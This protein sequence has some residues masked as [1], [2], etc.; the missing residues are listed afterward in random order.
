MQTITVKENQTLYDFALE[1]YGTCEA[2]GELLQLNADIINDP[3]ALRARGIDSIA[4][5]AFYL[6]IAVESDTQIIV[7]PN[8]MLRQNSVVKELTTDITTYD[9]GTND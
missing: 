1:Q 2:V 9:N 7:D 3:A 6:D 8:S 5:D 4:D